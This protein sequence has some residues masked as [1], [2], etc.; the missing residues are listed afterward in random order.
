[1]LSIT[2]QSLLMQSLFIPAHKSL[3][4]FQFRVAECY[5]CQVG[6]W[7]KSCSVVERSGNHDGSSIVSDWT[8]VL[9]LYWWKGI[10]A[11]SWGAR[12]IRIYFIGTWTF[13]HY[14]HSTAGTSTATGLLYLGV[15]HN[16]SA[17]GYRPSLKISVP[18]IFYWT[19]KNIGAVFSLHS[20]LYWKKL[21]AY[22]TIR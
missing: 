15:K 19:L 21:F 12:D 4:A 13:L 3:C 6:K 22:D 16:S 8:E 2:G 1:M 14:A 10:V 5:V 7:L 11:L 9:R 20:T 17:S 18:K